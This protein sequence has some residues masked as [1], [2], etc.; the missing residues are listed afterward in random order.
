[1]QYL[2]TKWIFPYTK[3]ASPLKIGTVNVGSTAAPLVV[4]G[5]VY[6]SMN[7]RRILAID[8]TTGKFLWNNSL[9][10]NLNDRTSTLARYPWISSVGG[11]FIQ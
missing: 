9:G 6:V 5:V 1:M 8:A 4:D 3:S 10:G 2:E 7:D 11:M